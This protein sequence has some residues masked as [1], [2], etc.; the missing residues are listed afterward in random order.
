MAT[1]QPCIE[2]WKRQIHLQAEELITLRSVLKS[3]DR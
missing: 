3:M 2:H 1:T